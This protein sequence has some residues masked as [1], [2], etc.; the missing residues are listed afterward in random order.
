MKAKDPPNSLQ[1]ELKLVMTY[2]LTLKQQVLFWLLES[3]PLIKTQNHVHSKHVIKIPYVRVYSCK[4][5]KYAYNF[6]DKNTSDYIY[7]Q[8]KSTHM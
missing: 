5:K 1:I 6:N 2:S 4:I 3:A 7:I 8:K